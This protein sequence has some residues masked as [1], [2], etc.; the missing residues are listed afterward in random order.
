MHGRPLLTH[1]QGLHASRLQGVHRR[2]P[3]IQRCGHFDA[4]VLQDGRVVPHHI[5]AVDIH[6]H[7]VDIAIFRDQ[8]DQRFGHHI[9]PAFLFVQEVERLELVGCHVRADQFPTGVALPA[10]RRVASLQAGSQHGAGVRAGAASHGCIDKFHIRVFRFEDLNHGLQAGCFA[11][12]CPPGKDLDF[13]LAA[14]RFG[15]CLGWLGLRF[16]LG[17][18]SLRF[19]LSRL[20]GGSCRRRACAEHQGEDHQGS[21]DTPA[22]IL[23]F[24]FLFTPSSSSLLDMGS[25]Y[26]VQ[27]IVSA[28]V[29]ARHSP[30]YKRS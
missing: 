15:L 10:I 23:A 20:R 30:P 19:S 6:R 18:L 13:L 3:L 25:Q 7:R 12:A 28:Y 16:S 22:M 8:R 9:Q 27:G 5:G 14:G 21:Q 2:E 1:R 4:V 29:K 17:W 24:H 11:A 26:W